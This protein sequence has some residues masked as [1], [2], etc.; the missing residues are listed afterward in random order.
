[1]IE[2]TDKEFHEKVLKK[3]LKVPIV[4]DFWASWCTPCQILGP[5]LERLEKEYKNKFVLVKISIEENKETAK[6]YEV[7]SIPSVK[8]IKNGKMVAEFTGALPEEVVRE[9]LDRNL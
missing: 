5:V 4:V 6:T 9:W 7:M 1:M 2:I 8:M 3:S